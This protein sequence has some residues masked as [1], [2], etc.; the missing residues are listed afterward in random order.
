MIA[1][2]CGISSHIQYANTIVQNMH[3][4]CN[5]TIVQYIVQKYAC[6]ENEMKRP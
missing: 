3:K 5:S 1:F 2:A 4:I 6:N